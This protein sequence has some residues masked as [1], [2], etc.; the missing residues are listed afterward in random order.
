MH[1][2]VYLYRL[3]TWES[4]LSKNY[5]KFLKEMP[6]QP[7]INHLL[8]PTKIMMALYMI[9]LIRGRSY[10][11]DHDRPHLLVNLNKFTMLY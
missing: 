10:T 11:I 7:F 3:K 2:M 4:E 5:L 8:D 6:Y 1:T 9:D